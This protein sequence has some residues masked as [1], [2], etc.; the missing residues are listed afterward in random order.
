MAINMA[1]SGRLWIVMVGALVALVPAAEA[2][3]QKTGKAAK[4]KP[5]G[6]NAGLVVFADS[7]GCKLWSSESAAKRM[8]EIASRG[9]VTWQ[10]VCKSGFISGTG[11]LREE[12]QS[13]LDG[14]TKKFA[15][16]LSGNAIRGVRTGRWKRES[17][18]KFSDSPTFTS[19]IATLEFVHGAA[20]GAPR[21]VAVTSWSQY[22]ASFSTR[23]LAPALKEQSL[24]A[25][26]R[27]SGSSG[28]L[29]ES[30]YSSPVQP[31]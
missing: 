28:I 1:M 24:A 26:A 19:G 12:G 5:A 11:V 20:L 29:A 30:Q 21:P 16:F 18:E 13:V 3:R 22:S 31:F 25:P 6:A 27:D 23:V 14:R 7:R 9:A 17:F 10:G 15:H 4:G 8:K 2:A